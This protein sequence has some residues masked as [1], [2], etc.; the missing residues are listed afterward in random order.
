MSCFILIFELSGGL[1]LLFAV[2]FLIGHLLKLDKYDE[3]FQKTKNK[4]NKE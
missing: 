1:I 4:Q 3:D 2:G